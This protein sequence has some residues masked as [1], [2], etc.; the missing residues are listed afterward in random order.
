MSQSQVHA[1]PAT[2]VVSHSCILFLLI[3]CSC[4]L[5]FSCSIVLL[6]ASSPS[7][8][9]TKRF[10]KASKHCDQVSGESTRD[11]RLPFL[12]LVHSY[13][14]CSAVRCTCLSSEPTSPVS[15]EAVCMRIAQ[16]RKPKVDRHEH[17]VRPTSSIPSVI[18]LHGGDSS[19]F[20][21]CIALTSHCLA[22]VDHVTA[23]A[24]LSPHHAIFSC[25]FACTAIDGLLSRRVDGTPFSHAFFPAR[26]LPSRPA[27][28]LSGPRALSLPLLQRSPRH[29][30]RSRGGTFGGCIAE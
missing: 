26:S 27:P 2:T 6:F 18:S 22:R 15:T 24:W 19:S 20:S 9:A 10:E 4:G 28:L 30:T 3:S 14:S 29:G 5:L 8:E 25:P 23:H 16:R 21:S 12:S 7:Q 17:P 13:T 1:I 11:A